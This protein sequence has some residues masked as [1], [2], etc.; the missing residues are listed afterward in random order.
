[1]EDKIKKVLDSLEY[2]EAESLIGDIDVSEPPDSGDGANRLNYSRI[3]KMVYDKT[4]VKRKKHFRMNKYILAAAAACIVFMIGAVS[5]SAG[6]FFFDNLNT[7]DG[8]LA[9]LD[10]HNISS[11]AI[12]WREETIRG[13]YNE[14]IDND[15]EEE[16]E[17]SSEKK[18]SSKKD[19]TSNE[20]SSESSVMSGD[21]TD[22][23]ESMPSNDVDKL[24]SDATSEIDM[25]SF[26]VKYESLDE[27]I[28]DSDYVVRGTKTQSILE[29][30]EDKD[31]YNLVAEFKVNN[32]LV[33]NMDDGIEKKVLVDEGIRYNAEEEKIVHVGGYRSMVKKKEYILFL[34]STAEGNYRIAGLVYGKVPIDKKEYVIDI[35]DAYSDNAYIVA[36]YNIVDEARERFGNKEDDMDSEITDPPDDVEYED[37]DEPE[38]DIYSEDKYDETDVSGTQ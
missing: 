3:Q 36:L 13:E 19:K 35:D 12:Q 33:D 37:G 23:Y 25:E 17:S 6:R 34:K 26:V 2:S 21:E 9:S 14:I 7:K 15:E 11:D 31:V 10:N 27:M 28:E 38:E 4:G 1:M 20:K 29:S 18:N 5:M 22:E 32:L 24:I 8:S 30:S 16:K